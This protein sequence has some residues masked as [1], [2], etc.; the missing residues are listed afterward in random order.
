[1]YQAG[2]YVR[3]E[4]LSSFIRLVCHTPELQ[5]YTSQRLYTA[6]LADVSQESLTLAAV[7]ILGEFGDILLQGGTFD[8]G[9]EVK[10]VRS[11]SNTRFLRKVSDA[12]LIDLL[13]LVLNSPY[14][15]LLTRQYVLTSISKISARLADAP[16]ATS[17][18]QQDR[19]AVLLASY[20][21]SLELE[22][23]QRAVEFGSLFAR[24]EIKGGVLERMPPPEIRATIMGT[25]E[26]SAV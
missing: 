13:E 20:S 14:A 5:F 17:S 26:L 25:G 24:D 8:D 18:T 22:I 6:L 23:Q 3:E 9:E 10:Q 15:N 4:V 11:F 21:S 7:W 1:M 19:I 2:N 12:D 16:S